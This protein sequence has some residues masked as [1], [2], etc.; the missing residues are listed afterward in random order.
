[1][2]ICI[3]MQPQ[4][5]TFVCLPEAAYAALPPLEVGHPRFISKLHVYIYR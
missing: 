3:D 5:G 1:M 2:Y 4:P